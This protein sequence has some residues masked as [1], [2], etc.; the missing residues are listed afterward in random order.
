MAA[1]STC[2]C[3]VLFAAVL[4]RMLVRR[5]GRRSEQVGA[6]GAL[7]LAL[8]ALTPLGSALLTPL[9]Q[10]F[11]ARDPAALAASGEV[12]AGIILL[13][14]GLGAALTPHGFA[15]DLKDAADRIRTAA[16]WAKAF[17]D[18]PVIVSGG[19][20]SP[21]PGAPSEADL[22]ADALAEYGVARTRIRREGASR[23]TAENAALLRV[24]AD[25]G[26]FILVTS[27]FHMPRSVGAL[28]AR[29]VRLVPAPCDWRVDRGETWMDFNAS[30]NL[31]RL[32]TAVKE[33]VGL[34]AYRVAGKSAAWFPGPEPALNR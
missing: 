15:P 18:A 19:P 12:V 16:A 11:P 7:A 1:P 4:V 34:V 23:T 9:E 24:E 28:R 30:E 10:R 13:G 29:G 6:A 27:A 20:V 21:L 3:I 25:A 8:A 31:K 33:Y 22:M 5:W 2:L 32:D 14:G 26:A 17:P